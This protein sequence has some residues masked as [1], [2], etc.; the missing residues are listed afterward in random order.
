MS[1]RRF[2][3]Q[4]TTF[5]R[6]L[7]CGVL[8]VAASIPAVAQLE[9]WMPRVDA[10]ET[11]LPLQSVTPYGFTL[12][13]SEFIR[14]IAPL[15]GSPY[16]ETLLNK[17]LDAVARRYHE[18]GY[19]FARFEPPK[20]NEFADGYYVNVRVNEGRIGEVVVQG[21]QHTREEVIR[22]QLLM[23]P[24]DLFQEEDL[25][26]SERILRSKRY[27]G[28]AV[29]HAEWNDETGRVD[30]I[31]VVQDLWSVIPRFR[32]TGDRDGT[33][34]RDVLDGKIGFAASVEDMNF[35]GT[36]QRWQLRFR[37]EI[38]QTVAQEMVNAPTGRNLIGVEFFEPNLFQSRWQL[39]TAYNQQADTEIDEWL[40]R[41]SHPLFSLR[42]EW[43]FDFFAL[44]T[45]TIQQYRRN[46]KFVREWE[47]HP[48]RQFLSVTRSWG[49]PRNQTQLSG[50]VSHAERDSKLLLAATP[51]IP[52]AS[53][54]TLDDDDPRRYEFSP[55]TLPSQQELLFGV[56]MTLQK[57][58]FAEELNVNRLGRV[59]DIPLGRSVTFSLGGG[60]QSVENDHDELRPSVSW[61]FV[62]R[63]GRDAL[64]SDRFPLAGSRV[65]W[66][67]RYSVSGSH[68]FANGRN[69]PDGWQDI[70]HRM[71]S[72]LFL[73]GSLDRMLAARMSLV[74]AVNMQDDFT[75]ILDDDFGARGY[76]RNAF[77]GQRRMLVNIEARQVFWT[78]P[79]FVAQ[80][81]VFA[82]AGYVW[83]D[84]LS[85]GDVKRSVGAGLRI[86]VL[87]LSSSPIARI[88]FAY[89]LDSAPRGFEISGS[90]GQYF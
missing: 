48:T 32:L 86:G 56:N 81:V 43:A 82:D 58:A 31:V 38:D 40:F 37:R 5:V 8:C 47:H 7:I 22:A 9:P 28:E 89:T 64:K 66:D 3:I 65:I 59:E 68:V 14:L 54:S 2:T 61:R 57:V 12:Y 44:E 67:G 88:D 36:G 62:K 30:L 63:W 33:S 71:E 26:E 19:L 20:V 27:I 35:S 11:N 25:Q 50:W 23:Q 46:G 85:L 80:G 60:L 55:E 16:D 51:V 13:K 18:D 39:T 10:S 6:H 83:W 1:S 90:T 75:L 74:S 42:T 70:V 77:D 76:A 78:H 24:D 73:R 45:G 21:A 69:G 49:S 53:F 4:R 34:V 72:R 29:I 84:S 87:K 15:E 17:A 41:V 52:Y 79:A